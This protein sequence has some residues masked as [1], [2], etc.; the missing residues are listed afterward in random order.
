MAKIN[1]DFWKLT[2][3]TG[4]SFPLFFKE[5]I[6]GKLFF[7]QDLK[8]DS[9]NVTISDPTLADTA[10]TNIFTPNRIKI[11]IDT[12]DITILQFIPM[13]TIM[14]NETGGTFKYNLTEDGDLKY[15]YQYNLNTGLGNKNAYE[16]LNDP[17]FIAAHG[18]SSY[19]TNVGWKTNVYP[20]SQTSPTDP[21]TRII[22]ECD[23]YKFRGRG[24][25]Q[26]TGRNNYEK[27]LKDIIRDKNKFTNSDTKNKINALGNSVDDKKLTELTNNTLDSLFKD[28]DVAVYVLK[29]HGSNTILKNMYSLTSVNDYLNLV[30]DYGNAIGG[31][32][33]DNAYGKLFLNRVVQILTAITGWKVT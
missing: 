1:D 17:I 27:F 7:A 9:T 16:L 13:V 8:G 5:K 21:L 11:M 10:L 23:F 12:D 26:L 6:G 32:A 24:L 30:W 28:E 29:S 15:T 20:I 33:Y 25:I 14:I 31:P 3:V 4:K 18:S 22:K 19:K 2:S